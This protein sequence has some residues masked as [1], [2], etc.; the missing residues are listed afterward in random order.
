MK[1]RKK[2]NLIFDLEVHFLTNAVILYSKILFTE[3]I[4]FYLTILA[5]I[6]LVRR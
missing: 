4:T 1:S 6:L 2:N 3:L 5:I